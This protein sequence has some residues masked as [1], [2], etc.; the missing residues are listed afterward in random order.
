[1]PTEAHLPL[2]IRDPEGG[3]AGP[4]CPLSRRHKAHCRGSR[5]GRVFACSSPP[6]LSALL[7][8]G[9]RG[10]GCGPGRPQPLHYSLRQ[11]PPPPIRGPTLA[12]TPRPPAFL[13]GLPASS[14]PLPCL[15][16]PR[17]PA[18]TLRVPH[19]LHTALHTHFPAAPCVGRCSQG[20][21]V[22]ESLPTTLGSFCLGS[23]MR[24]SF[25]LMRLKR[26]HSRCGAFFLPSESSLRGGA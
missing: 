11:G 20:D 3:G 18:S 9:G 14:G 10:R 17:P 5:Q 15:V 12:C 19:F 8:T 24:G 6:G 16:S 26:P 25:I 4:A 21:P 2:P 1:M 23:G 7:Q 13:P 22:P